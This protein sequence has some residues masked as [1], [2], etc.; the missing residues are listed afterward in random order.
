MHLVFHSI[1][2]LDLLVTLSGGH[3]IVSFI[4]SYLLV[5][6]E[7]TLTACAL[8]IIIKITD[9]YIATCNDDQLHNTYQH[10][11]Y[12]AQNFGGGKL[13]QIV[14]QKVLIGRLAAL[15]IKLVL[16][17]FSVLQ[18]FSSLYILLY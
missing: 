12:I 5:S 14:V 6:L 9:S 2:G 8:I 3:T 17:E 10:K 4:F 15:Y 1:V 11:C 18:V 16:Q 7:E 13:W